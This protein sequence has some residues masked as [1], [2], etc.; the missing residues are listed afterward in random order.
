MIYTINGRT[1]NEVALYAY[2]SVLRHGQVQESRNG[3]VHFLNNVAMSLRDPR[4]RHLY[5]EG[6]KSNI[7]AQIAETF[8][9][10]AGDDR[11]D[12]FLSFFLPRA[13]D[14]SD[15]GVTWRG[16]YGPRLY[17]YGQ[18]QDAVDA[19]IEEGIN[20]RRSVIQILLPEFDSKPALTVR[21]LDGTKDR[22]CNNELVL[23]CTKDEKSGNYRLNMN[24]YQRSGD[25]IWGALNINVFEWTMLQELLV[26]ILNE[27]M[28]ETVVLGEFTHIVANLH[29][30][31][32]TAKQARDAAG[33]NGNWEKVLTERNAETLDLRGMT[34]TDSVAKNRQLFA[35]LVQLLTDAIDHPATNADYCDDAEA[36]FELFN[37]YGV[38]W[39][40]NQLEDYAM[41]VLGYIYSKKDGGVEVVNNESWK[42]APRSE[43][44]NN[45]LKAS[46]F[47]K[48][49]V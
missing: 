42:V 3:G 15:D 28:E 6:R 8:W 24:C 31:D 11:I 46:P 2:D 30:Y 9:V 47:I 25:A 38:D 13:K 16:A 48:F 29:I 5:L 22:P 41:I 19:F 26:Y 43:D 40:N 37:E 18:L 20:T 39:N 49:E 27:N 45:C 44:L 21:G 4:A 33:A 10:L 35:D 34:A 17:V 7:A 23:F 32:F 36:I 14:Y 1:V 12:P